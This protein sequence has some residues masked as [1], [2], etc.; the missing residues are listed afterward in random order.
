[1]KECLIFIIDALKDLAPLFISV[2]AIW[3][4]TRYQNHSKKMETDRMLKELFAEFNE[5]YDKINNKLDVISK[6]SVEQWNELSQTKQSE[7]EGVIVDFFNICAEE[8]YWHKEGR[9]NG[10]IWTSWEKGMNDIYN[11]SEIIQNIWEQECQ[12]SGFQSYYITKP[13]TFF[14]VSKI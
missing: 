10:N 8:Y 13:N 1:M 2:I 7:N 12:N 5:R 6:L 4:T 11:R 14:K 9:I 3:L